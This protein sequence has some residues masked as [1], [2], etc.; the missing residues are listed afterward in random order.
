MGHS[1]ETD[2]LL[3][4]QFADTDK[5]TWRGDVNSD[6]NKIDLFATT[7]LAVLESV[8][9]AEDLEWHNGGDWNAAD[10]LPAISDATGIL[11]TYYRVA[12]SGV[13]NLGSGAIT[14][15]LED[16][17]YFDGVQWIRIPRSDL[18]PWN[19]NID[20]LPDATNTDWNN[21]A[22]DATAVYAAY[23]TTFA[24]G[25]VIQWDE[26]IGAGVWSLCVMGTVGVHMGIITVKI[27]GVA[28]GTLDFYAAAALNN[29]VKTLADFT[30]GRTGKKTISLHVDTKN[31]ASD[32]FWC[33]IQNLRMKR[34]S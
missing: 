2:T 33:F 12:T 19:I 25:A 15:A 1:T 31:V 27:D 24:E 6:N 5:P 21:V 34:V 22:V 26:I 30:V 10:N 18:S 9:T 28:V 20:C 16:T 3:L 8:V 29:V 11:N 13:R 17:V 32:A 23:K 14:F 7:T 4:S